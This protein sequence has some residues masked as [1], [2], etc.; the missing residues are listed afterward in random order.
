MPTPI[1]TVCQCAPLR[2]ATEADPDAARPLQGDALP[3]D[4]APE[5][6]L[7]A[8]VATIAGLPRLRHF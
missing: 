3:S 7:P 6:D 5:G 8:I 2:S 4:V 1:A